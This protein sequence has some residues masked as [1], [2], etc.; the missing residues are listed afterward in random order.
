[1]TIRVSPFYQ[2]PF[3]LAG[4]VMLAA[5]NG[6]SPK[7]ATDGKDTFSYPF[8]QQVISSQIN[9]LDSGGQALTYV[10]THRGKPDTSQVKASVLKELV[11]PFFLTS[12]PSPDWSDGSYRKAQFSDSVHHLRIVSYEAI[13][14]TVKLN[15]VD[16]SLDSSTGAIRQVYIQQVFINPDSTIRKQLI[17]KADHFISLITMVDKQTYTADIRKQKFTWGLPTP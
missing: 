14:D 15:R 13:S 16:V 11:T 7:V 2:M 1:M 3:V 8:I 9:Q 12:A 17:W 5:C 6:H 10:D 4:F